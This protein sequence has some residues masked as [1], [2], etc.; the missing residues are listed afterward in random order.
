MNVTHVEMLTIVCCVMWVCAC[1][2]PAGS[3]CSVTG[4]PRTVRCMSAGRYL[5]G[6]HAHLHSTSKCSRCGEE[7]LGV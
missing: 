7:W 2:L 1:S 5:Q 3:V 6:P 4:R